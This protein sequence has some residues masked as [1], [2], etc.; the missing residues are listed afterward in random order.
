M[1]GSTIRLAIADDHEIVL[2]GVK[3]II[4]SFGGFSIDIEA[5]NGKDLYN[6]LTLAD[7]L[8]DIVVMDISMPVWDGYETLDAIRRKWP[9]LK[10]LILTMHKHELA[11]I[12]MFR[13]G[14]N[15][16]LLKNSP[17]KDL[18]KAL[19]S[20]NETGIFFSE[21]ASGNLFHRL[22][23]SNIMPSLSPKEIQ[24]LKYSHID[25]TYKEIADKMGITER[26]VAGY[27]TSLFEKLGVNSR[28]G[29]VVCGIQMGLIPVE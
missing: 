20:I 23:Y 21:I 28:A 1:M 25:I 10:V 22:Q 26:S 24:L 15:G 2:N 29:L 7:Q 5:N 9:T 19:H 4:L 14:A 16:F 27:R 8:P 13:S 17:P 6:K 12:K 18:E 11:I 3:E